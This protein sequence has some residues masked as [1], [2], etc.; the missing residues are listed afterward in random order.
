MTKTKSM[1]ELER[2][3]KRELPPH[4]IQW[5][6]RRKHRRMTVILED[7]RRAVVTVSVTPSD[8]RFI[9]NHLKCITRQIQ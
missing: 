1:R 2:A 9:K 3:M 7:G 4:Q 8:H 6:M 5:A